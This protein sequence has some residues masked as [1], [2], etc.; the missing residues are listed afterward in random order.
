M[1]Q[2][3]PL[4]SEIDP[5][6]K[7]NAESVFADAAAW[8]AEVQAILAALPDVR[9]FQGKLADAATLAEAFKAVEDL[10]ARAMRI[11]V[12]ANFSS[13]VDTTD[14][15][16]AAMVGKAQGMFGQVAAAAAFMEPELIALGEAT[17][18]QWVADEPRLA[19][20]D[21]YVDDLFRQQAH[22][23]SAEVEEV[24]GLLTDVGRGPY[25]TATML[26]NADFK[27]PAAR[28]D[29]G[30]EVEITQGSLAGIMAGADRSARKTAWET[31]MDQHLAF[32]NTLASNL[33]TAVKMD[34][35]R[36]RVR[37]H[38]SALEA[39]LFGSN[40]PVEVYHNL[41]EVFKKN[42]PVWQRYFAI[43]RKA[44]G[45]DKLYP[46]D[47]WAPLTKD[48]VKLSYE[49]AVDLI[50]AG[51]APMGE[52]YV[53]TVRRGCFEQRWVDVYPNQGKREGAFSSGAPG[54]YPFI[55]M[56]FNDNVFSLSTLAHELG[57]SLHSHLTRK[58][59]PLVYARYSLF[60]AEVASNFHQAM[61]RDYLL[62]NKTEADFQIAVIEEA[63]ANFYRYFF[64]MPTLARF[65][66]EAHTRVEKG[67]PLTADSMIALTAD[68]FS[69]AYGDQVEVDRERVGIT[70]ATFQHM[71]MNF[72]VYAYSTGISGAN[73]LS[74]RILN[75]EPGAV[76]DYLEFLK[77]GS[78]LY[79]L[80]ALK[81]A[82]VDLATPAP[83]E[84]AFAVME[85]YVDRLE[86]LLA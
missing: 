58:H 62:K 23:R 10:T 57:H 78:S 1:T 44:L 59:Q 28:D 5:K 36:S 14:Q 77:A 12:Y 35:F 85:S 17:L 43:R 82:G 40:I 46:Y 15:Q 73:A 29:Q 71:F 47:M 49:E 63:M 6:Y 64:I 32:K 34:V 18:R 31:Y 7:W 55:M 3:V 53:A 65:E 30:N 33:A 9:N 81:R 68:L 38:G 60:A 86:K 26:T 11:F 16:A 61:V 56:S 25:T 37:R 67:Q 4:R 42:F 50:C 48:E 83:V 20:Y 2:K 69:E 27:F 21:H 13:A 75:G 51:L 79:A 52:E 54:T 22:V 70:F 39:S 72:Y 84:A 76:E 45:V 24:L 74:R 19:I 80:D 8:D 66:L 41:L